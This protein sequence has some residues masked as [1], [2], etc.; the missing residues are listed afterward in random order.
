MRL[1]EVGRLGQEA[2]KIG[3]RERRREASLFVSWLWDARQ[4]CHRAVPQPRGD[5]G[6]KR[7][8]VKRRWVPF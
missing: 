1:V 6:L 3:R 8:I 4:S 7:K 2:L 5:V